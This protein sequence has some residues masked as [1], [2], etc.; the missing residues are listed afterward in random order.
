MR[1]AATTV[2][3]GPA[4]TDRDR[5]TLRTAAYGA[6]TLMAAAGAPGSPHPAATGALYSATVLVGHVLDERS[7]GVRL[8]SASVAVIAAHALPALTRAMNLL[9]NRAPAEAD[10]F[11]ATVIVA[12][13]FAARTHLGEPSPELAEMIRKITAALDAFS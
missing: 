3:A 13:E 8:S 4:L 1:P 10:T 6:V 5:L 11:R 9:R 12:A 2:A 7:K